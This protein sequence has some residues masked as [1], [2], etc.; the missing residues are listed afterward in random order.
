[1]I[2]RKDFSQ[3][4]QGFGREFRIIRDDRGPGRIQIF[5]DAVIF[6]VDQ[7]EILRHPQ[8]Q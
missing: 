1:M 6:P 2:R 7:G 5:G 4:I 8:M 3:K